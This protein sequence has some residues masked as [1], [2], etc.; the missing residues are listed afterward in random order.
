MREPRKDADTDAAQ[1]SLLLAEVTALRDE[2]KREGA[3][4]VES[5][6]VRIADP[7]AE[8]RALN[9][10]H[11]VALRGHDLIDLQYRL[12]ARG[13]SSLGRS[14][15][16][17]I[18][19]LEALIATLRRL[20]GEK[21]SSYPAAGLMRAGLSDLDA[22]AE[23]L[24]GAGRGDGPRAR[25]LATLPPEAA[26]DPGLARRLVEAGMDCA[27][28][29]C[30]HDDAAA[31]A[32]MIENIRSAET[33][34][35]RSCRVLM[36]IAGPKCR[37]TGVSAAPKYRIQRGDRLVIVRKLGRRAA[38]QPTFA[39]SF[40]DIIDQLEVGAEVFID[41]GKAAARVTEKSEG[42][43]EIEVY[44][45]REKGVRLKTD[46]GLNFPSTEIELP[47]LTPKD[48][49]DLDFVADSRR[50]RGLFVR[51]THSGH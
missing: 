5:W 38:S 51:T 10:G 48:F 34:T 19:A 22:E 12:A 47:P 44:A 3:S 20:T 35:G 30:A 46:K 43:A 11:Y 15:A 2:V 14:E 50:S 25:I 21:P 45:A 28:I 26:D 18:P 42:R 7:A 37:V 49:R 9:L 4:L 36:D 29:N 17:V 24:F 16:R 27:R 31:W 23:R 41:D 8:A 1:L 39:I 40:P 6:G 13:L 32:R 33:A